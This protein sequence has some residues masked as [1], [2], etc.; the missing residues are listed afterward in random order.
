M[1]PSVASA[2]DRLLATARDSAAF[3]ERIAE[4]KSVMHAASCGTANAMGGV[5]S[6]EDG[7]NGVDNGAC[8]A[9]SMRQFLPKQTIRVRSD[10]KQLGH[11]EQC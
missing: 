8:R 6:V 5:T 7:A 3:P 9:D 4:T 2:T 10:R 1:I 11:K